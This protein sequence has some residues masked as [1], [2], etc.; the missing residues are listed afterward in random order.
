MRAVDAVGEVATRSARRRRSADL[1]AAD[2]GGQLLTVRLLT[3][4]AA[5]A[6]ATLAGRAHPW[7]LAAAFG[8]LCLCLAWGWGPSLSIRPSRRLVTILGGTGVLVAMAVIVADSAAPLSLVPVAL[9][10]G[11]V[12]TFLAQLVRRDDRAGLTEEVVATL[13]GLAFVGLGSGMIPLAL[14]DVGLAAVTV[15]MAGVAVSVVADLVSARL[16]PSSWAILLTAALGGLAGGLV[17]GALGLP[18]AWHGILL[19]GVCAVLS[20]V[21]RRIL[22]VAPGNHGL[23]GQVG[24]ACASVLVVGVLAQALARFVLVMTTGLT[25]G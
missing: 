1:S 6:L 10:I 16:G 24:G 20:Y 13:G 2:L 5:S 9:A 22:E 4:V 15:A 8:W 7:A 25:G 19:G 17:G 23:A 12:V 14:T 18:V 3:V 21:V 11:I